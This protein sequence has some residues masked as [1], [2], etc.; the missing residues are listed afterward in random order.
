MRSLYQ[1]KFEELELVQSRTARYVLNRCNNFSSV[2]EMPQE[3]QW[4]T[5]EERQKKKNRLTMFYKIDNDQT[6][7][8]TGKY[9]KPLVRVSR[10]VNNQAYEV[11]FVLTNY[12]KYTYF[13]NTIRE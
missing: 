5:L 10:H 11:P 12:Y 2:N 3:L 1:R 9:L 7:I 6:G 13:P 4:N 8:D